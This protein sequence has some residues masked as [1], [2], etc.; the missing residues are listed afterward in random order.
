MPEDVRE[1]AKGSDRGK[2]DWQ[3]VQVIWQATRPEGKTLQL[4]VGG[5]GRILLKARQGDSRLF[6]QLTDGEASSLLISLLK[7][8]MK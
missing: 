7:V 2:I 5:D 4:M 3:K 1:M 6:F 8:L